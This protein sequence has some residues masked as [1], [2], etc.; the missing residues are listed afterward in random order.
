MSLHPNQHATQVS[1]T[2][3]LPE[4]VATAK[5]GLFKKRWSLEAP[6]GGP[7][8]LEQTDPEASDEELRDEI[9]SYT[10]VCPT[11]IYRS[12][13]VVATVAA[14]CKNWHSSE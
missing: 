14:V 10:M 9:S 12:H 2:A 5:Y 7:F 3:D 11:T 6:G 8:Y 1:E 4:V 13:Q